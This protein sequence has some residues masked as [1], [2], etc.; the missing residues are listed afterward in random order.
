MTN[1]HDIRQ[2]NWP[3]SWETLSGP[4]SSSSDKNDVL[5]KK[6]SFIH[7]VAKLFYLSWTHM[8]GVLSGWIFICFVTHTISF[9]EMLGWKIIRGKQICQRHPTKFNNTQHEQ[10]H[11]KT[12][13]TTIANIFGDHFVSISSPQ[14]TF[15]QPIRVYKQNIWRIVLRSEGR[16][17]CIYKIGNGS[18][19][20]LMTIVTEKCQMSWHPSPKMTVVMTIIMTVDVEQI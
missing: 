19:L 5:N 2:G 9:N 1:G 10:Q 8:V 15:R 6:N 14:A 4:S 16:I 11:R 3:L 18:I 12:C 13:E 20:L 7:F 17:R